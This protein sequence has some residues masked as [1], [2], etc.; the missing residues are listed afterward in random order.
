MGMDELVLMK[1]GE[2][3]REVIIEEVRE[4]V[5]GK[6]RNE[7]RNEVIGKVRNEV[8]NE[9]I[10][11]VRNEVRE[12]VI[13]K[14]RN[15]VREEVIGEVRDSFIERGEKNALKRNVFRLLKKGF[16]VEQ[17]VDLLD[18]PQRQVEDLFLLFKKQ[19]RTETE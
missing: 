17:I 1:Y 5:I 19:E 6:V 2:L 7:V 13:G 8:R 4:E 16:S 9:V 14:V 11:E 15:E 3:Y 10:G 18:I 12:E